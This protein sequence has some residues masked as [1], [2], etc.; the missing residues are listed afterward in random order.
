MWPYAPWCPNL[1][2]MDGMPWLGSILD[3]IKKFLQKILSITISTLLLIWKLKWY[4]I[5]VL[6][7]LTLLLIAFYILPNRYAEFLYQED[8]RKARFWLQTVAGNWSSGSEVNELIN[9]GVISKLEF[10]ISAAVA[11]LLNNFLFI[12]IIG[13]IWKFITQRKRVMRVADVLILEEFFTKKALHKA[14]SQTI[15]EVVSRDTTAKPSDQPLIDS[16]RLDEILDSAFREGQVELQE[17]L[18]EVAEDRDEALKILKLIA[19]KRKVAVKANNS[20]PK[21]E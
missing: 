13:F 9:Q 1:K 11:V 19:E 12:I 14:L 4:A 5:A 8:G 17:T 18:P 20:K 10:A 21:P 7:I 3:H 16:R 15:H 6:V 2:R